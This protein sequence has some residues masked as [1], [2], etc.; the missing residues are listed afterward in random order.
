MANSGGA[1]KKLE[2]LIAQMNADHQN[3]LK[4]L[5]GELEDEIRK[6]KE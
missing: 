1:Q 2:E 5:R 6:L 4:Q 3:A